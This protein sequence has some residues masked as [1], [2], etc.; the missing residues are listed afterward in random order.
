MYMKM[1]IYSVYI[2]CIYIYICIIYIY[3]YI[4]VNIYIYIYVL[5]MY[6]YICIYTCIVIMYTKRIQQ[7]LE[8]VKI[9]PKTG[10]LPSPVFR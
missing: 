3:I 2:I 7:I 9:I 6:M 8:H 5:Y 4:Y 1:C 10:H